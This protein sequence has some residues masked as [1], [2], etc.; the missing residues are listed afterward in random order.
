MFLH[1][2]QWGLKYIEYGI[3]GTFYTA[4]SVCVAK[5]S[6]SR[7][8]SSGMGAVNDMDRR[9]TGWVKLRCLACSICLWADFSNVSKEV[10]FRF[11]LPRFPYVYISSPT[12]G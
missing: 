6:M 9:S 5:P 2:L 8:M 4:Y 3:L 11:F 7:C 12:I 1:I 10:P